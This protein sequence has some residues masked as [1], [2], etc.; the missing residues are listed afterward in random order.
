[1]TLYKSDQHYHDYYYIIVRQTRINQCK[2]YFITSQQKIPNSWRYAYEIWLSVNEDFLIIACVVL[3]QRQ[4]M[5]D[6]R[7]NDSADAHSRVFSALNQC[8][9][10]GVSLI[11]WR[12]KTRMVCLSGDESSVT[13]MFRR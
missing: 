2:K 10:V 13:M 9:F 3:A 6:R 4:R 7:M 12:K 11:F 5:T 1:M 8:H